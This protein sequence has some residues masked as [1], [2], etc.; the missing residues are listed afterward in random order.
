MSQRLEIV[1]RHQH[2]AARTALSYQ[3]PD[4]SRVTWPSVGLQWSPAI[5]AAIGHRYRRFCR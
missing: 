3:C 1:Q 5:P 2:S 4:V